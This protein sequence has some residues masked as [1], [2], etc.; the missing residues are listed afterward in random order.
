[1]NDFQMLSSLTLQE[2]NY[3]HEFYEVLDSQILKLKQDQE[4]KISKTMRLRDIAFDL[5]KGKIMR[6]YKNKK[7]D[8]G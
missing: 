2:L 4:N 5:I 1:M 8:A 6:L 3:V 7:K